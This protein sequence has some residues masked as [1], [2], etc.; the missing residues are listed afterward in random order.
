MSVDFGLMQWKLDGPTKLKD[1]C[2]RDQEAFQEY[3]PPSSQGLNYQLKDILKMDSSCS[4]LYKVIQQMTFI[5][6]INIDKCLIWL[7]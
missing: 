4:P 5:R 2:S 3:Q 1:I 7:Y 6:N